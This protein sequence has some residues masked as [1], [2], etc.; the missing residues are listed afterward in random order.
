[1]NFDSRRVAVAL[2][3]I[4]AFLDLYAPQALLP[5]LAQEFGAGPADVS[6]L[7]SAT[8]LGVAV[9]APFT[10]AVA[11]VLGRKRVI[12]TAMFVLTVP[13]AII[14]FAG[15]LGAMVLWRFAQGLLLPPIFA[16]TV[17]YISEEWPPKESTAVNGVFI[18]ACSFGGFL[19][20]F[21]TGV[22]ADL[23]GWRPAFFVLAAITLGCAAAVAALLPRERRFVRAESLASSFRQMLRHLRNARLVATYGVGF[24]V[25]FSFIAIF[26]YVNFHLAA[27]PFGLSTTALGLIFIVYL[28]GVVVTPLTGRW[29]AALGR[30]RLVFAVIAAWVAGLGL[31][32]VSSLPLIIAGLAVA[33]ACGF[34][35]QAIST[36]F[37]AQSAGDGRSAAVGLYVTSFY[38]GGSVGGILPG[39][40]WPS[41]GWPGV[42]AMV[43]AIVLGIAV[44]VGRFWP[45]TA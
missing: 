34:L 8:S 29:V 3:G 24:S 25:L 38:L 10:G 20:R 40:V 18:T 45:K 23:F 36:S 13:V 4:C 28:L 9:V 5:M 41:A 39:V 35:C 7:I 26:T 6:A 14:G 19:S 32:L 17:A 30:R 43:I 31:T 1:M 42:V 15:S 27:P 2:A 21:L 37:V 22:L 11:D 16:V 33:A 44:I 12:A